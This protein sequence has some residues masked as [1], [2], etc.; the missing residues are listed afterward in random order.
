MYI[1]CK[2]K[3]IDFE[4]PKVMGIVNITPDSF[5]DGSRNKTVQ[6]ALT[7]AEKML[8]EGASFIDVGAYSSRPGATDI[9]VEEEERRLLPVIEALVDKF[10]EVILSV[11]TFRS[12][13]AKRAI[14]AGAA[15]INDISAGKLD[16]KMMETVAELQVPY[17]MMHMHGTP[18]TMKDLNEYEDLV[19][20][21]LFYFSERIAVAR[22][23]GINDLIIDPGF[24]FSKNIQQNFE[25]LSKL[26]LF[27]N[28]KLPILSGLS[29]KSLIYKT[30][31]TTPEEALNGTTVLNTVSLLKG[32]NILRVHDVKEAMECV[33]LTGRLE[34]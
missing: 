24:G 26:E 15:I 7:L 27:Q 14:Q 4:T 23:H 30:F 8:A 21:V 34:N 19:A 9:S 13:V 5:Y 3:L 22:Y 16:G 1:N 10:P 12:E 6:D 17:I 28:L 33:K 29:R 20:D 11:D 25:L 32:A 18:Q 2:G 31:Q